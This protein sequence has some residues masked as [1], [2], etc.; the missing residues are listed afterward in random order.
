M[1]NDPNNYALVAGLILTMTVLFW[2][3]VW[4]LTG[5]CEPVER[6]AWRYAIAASILSVAVVAGGEWFLYAKVDQTIGAFMLTPS[7]LLGVLALWFGGRGVYL[8]LG[9]GQEQPTRAKFA[10]ETATQDGQ[11]EI[12]CQLR[13]LP[14]FRETLEGDLVNLATGDWVSWTDYHDQKVIEIKFGN[15][16]TL[17]CA[18]FE[19]L[20]KYLAV[21]RGMARWLVPGKEVE[22]SGAG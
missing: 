19:T 1:A 8:A 4:I 14:H 7:F 20:T 5:D 18:R 2:I 21:Q 13:A 6:R 11:G 15:K 16:R 9:G 17:L 22:N 10:I 3:F 12:W